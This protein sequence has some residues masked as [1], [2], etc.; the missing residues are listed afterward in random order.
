[1]NAPLLSR[2]TPR[3]MEHSVLEEI[4][5]QRHS[6]V[7]ELIESIRSS[8]VSR[9]K[10]HILLTGSRGI[11][12]THLVSLIYHRIRE[13]EELQKQLFI[14]W[15][16][17]EEWSITSFLDFL[18]CIFN[19]L[20]VEST[21]T[22][23]PSPPSIESLYE[24]SVDA[25]EKETLVLLK[26]FIG[27]RT[28][29][30]I[31]ENLDELLNGL[32]SEEQKQ[33][34]SFIEE[35]SCVML[36][37]ASSLPNAVKRKSS[38][39]YQFFNH[40]ELEE[41][42]LEDARDLLANI[43]KL[44]GNK[45]LEDFI[46]TPIGYNRIQAVYHLAGGNHRLYVIFSEFLTHRNSLDQLVEAFMRILDDL[47]PYYQDRMR[48]ISPQQRKIIEFLCKTR[49]AVPVKEISQRCFMTHQTAS[50]QL[51]KLSEMGYVCS[52][53]VGRESYYE[54]KETMMRFCLE[55]KKQQGEPIK[56]I[57]S[58][59]LLWYTPIEL[60]QRLQ[61]LQDDGTR[62]RLLDI[63]QALDQE[64]FKIKHFPP[65]MKSFG[66]PEDIEK[67]MI[68][69]DDN[70]LKEHKI[71]EVLQKIEK[72]V[73]S[74]GYAPVDWWKQGACLTILKQYDRALECFNKAVEIEP[75][76][77]IVWFSKC[78]LL[79][80]LNEDDEALACCNKIIEIDEPDQGLIWFIQGIILQKLKRY[81]E[82]LVSYTKAIEIDSKYKL[83]WFRKGEVLNKLKLYPEALVCFEQVIE[84]DKNFVYAWFQRGWTLEELG[85][86]EEALQAYQK[87]IKLDPDDISA[88]FNQGLILYKQENYKE[89]LILFDQV[90]EL[91]SKD[92]YAW[93]IRGEILQELEYYEEAL[94]SFKKVIE[95]D[96]NNT[97]AWI[98]QGYILDEMDCHEKAL[99]SYDKVIELEPSN[100][101]AWGGR[102]Y[103]LE[104]LRRHQEALES[105][106][107]AIELGEQDSYIFFNRVESLLAL[108]RW[109]EGIVAL[110]NALERFAHADEPDTGDTEA[111]TRY[112]FQSTY[113]VTIW[114]ARVK[115]LI[116]VYDKHEVAATLGKGVVESIPILQS[117]MVSEK[118]A[119][120]W[121]ELWKETVGDHIDF[122][123]PLR[124]L[125]AAVRYRQKKGD[126]RVLLGLPIEERKLLMPLLGLEESD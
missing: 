7:E 52:E 22:D 86:Y 37:T 103:V 107:K 108:N 4:F 106:N 90:I 80:N 125:E 14:A 81:Q 79:Q 46:K 74:Q 116:E 75:K 98:N 96:P 121:L 64:N 120:A 93:N 39:F 70:K 29:L 53:A 49:T 119:Q 36:A 84:L 99:A 105:S 91:D 65:S 50:S 11:G 54:V 35:N 100:E 16:S 25:M 122:Q 10:Q 6:Q 112:L 111:I 61:Q 89:A 77:L 58:F 110:D 67:F 51:K 18:I 33:L 126:R 62:K 76:N 113:E 12:K 92:I 82:A 68:F 28:L 40:Q 17:E 1:M 124:L 38:T 101:L 83:A 23:Q 118:A 27:D 3:M 69:L 55:V 32:D 88:R 9:E 60:Q 20:Q 56:L 43:A 30:L 71:I 85:R 63:L 73:G 115:A 95:L 15:L 78:L 31:V 123:I 114:K 21:K 5:V 34:R 109:D 41:L 66:H 57:I 13:R 48:S 8:V 117:A 87:V 102:A 26:E 59:L 45:E 42:K 72:R 97:S 94:K 2:Y 19:T 44:K 47:T 104:S 24:M